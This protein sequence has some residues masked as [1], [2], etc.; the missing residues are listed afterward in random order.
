MLWAVR[1]FPPLQARALETLDGLTALAGKTLL[2][3][4]PL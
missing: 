4:V 1:S 3:P 2:V